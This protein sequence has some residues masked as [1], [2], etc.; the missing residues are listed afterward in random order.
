[1]ASTQDAEAGA[2]EVLGQPRKLK[3]HTH[4]HTLK[5]ENR[6]LQVKNKLSPHLYV[7]AGYTKGKG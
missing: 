2:L 3:S 7:Y 6:A 1:M 4:T 5:Q